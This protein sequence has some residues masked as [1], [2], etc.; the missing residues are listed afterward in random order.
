MAERKNPSLIP[1]VA[2][3]VAFV[4]LVAAANLA[5]GGPP[6]AAAGGRAVAGGLLLFVGAVALAGLAAPLAL[7]ARGRLTLPVWATPGTGD[8]AAAVLLAIFLFARVEMLVA[9]FGEGRPWGPA[10]ATF[11]GPAA[12]HL[13]SVTATVGVLL[14]ALKRRMPAAPAAIL[15]ALAWV[16]YH[17]AQFNAYPEGREISHLLVIA[18]FGLGYAL[19]YFWSR[20][21]LL[22]ALLQ[23]LV[24][25]TTFIYHG[26]Y[27]FG[28][29]DAPFYFSIIIVAAF[30]VVVLLRRRLFAAQRFTHF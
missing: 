21:L 3:Y 11:F 17:A 1:A 23:H 9:I 20:S 14:P 12:I 29:L 6:E 22:T 18:V 25:T 19:Y 24:A 30:L 16:V 4:V 15:A 26:D 7:A 13:A 10:V 28:T 8:K 5:L 27:A 2:I